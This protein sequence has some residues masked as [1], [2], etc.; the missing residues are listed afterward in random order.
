MK[1]TLQLLPVIIVRGQYEHTDEFKHIH[2]LYI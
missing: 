2:I 1:T